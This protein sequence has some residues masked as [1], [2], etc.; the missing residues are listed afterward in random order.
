MKFF[1]FVIV[2]IN[3]PDFLS[4]NDNV[5]D[6]SLGALISSPQAFPLLYLLDLAQNAFTGD[7]HTY[8]T[9]TRMVPR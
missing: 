7:G 8:T 9:A 2:F 1:K 6:G 5:L 4:L 3:F